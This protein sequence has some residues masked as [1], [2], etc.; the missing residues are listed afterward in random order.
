MTVLISSPVTLPPQHLGSRPPANDSFSPQTTVHLQLS[1]RNVR[2]QGFHPEWS[3][4]WSG[5]SVRKICVSGR[6]PSSSLALLPWI[7][8]SFLMWSM[9]IASEEE[10]NRWIQAFFLTAPQRKQIWGGWRESFSLRAKAKVLQELSCSHV[11]CTIHKN[12]FKMEWARDDLFIR[13]F[14]SNLLDFLFN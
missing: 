12:F 10:R 8:P 5:W 4:E 14:S 1:D 11:I 13:S 3:V 7:F 6:S 2:L 9:S